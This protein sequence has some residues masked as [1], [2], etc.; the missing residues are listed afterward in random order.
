L[1]S[2]HHLAMQTTELLQWFVIGVEEELLAFEVLIEV[3]HPPDSGC[4]LQQDW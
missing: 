4:S 3:I 1:E 2:V